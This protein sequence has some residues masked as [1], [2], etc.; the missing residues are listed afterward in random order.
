VGERWEARCN[1]PRDRPDAAGISWRVVLFMEQRISNEIIYGIIR[2]DHFNSQ[3]KLE[4]QFILILK[5]LS[6]DN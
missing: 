1:V 2:K 3:E 4:K 5:V 6:K